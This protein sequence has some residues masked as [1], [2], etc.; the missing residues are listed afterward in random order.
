MHFG[1]RK[2]RNLL[3]I[4]D[5]VIDSTILARIGIR[6]GFTTK[7]AR[8]YA[9][10]VALLKKR[11]F[12]CITLDLGLGDETGIWILNFLAELRSKASIVIVSGAAQD[13]CDATA[14]FGR[15]IGLNVHGSLQKPV[16]PGRLAETMA[17]LKAESRLDR[18]AAAVAH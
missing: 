12:D 7:T 16:P 8:S 2:R 3:V 4:E 10:A 15:S 1:L 6:N 14:Q 18:T 5:A 11:N 17:E 9:D 13:V